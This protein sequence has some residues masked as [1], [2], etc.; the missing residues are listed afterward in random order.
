MQKRRNKHA[1]SR[2]AKKHQILKSKAKRQRGPVV[3]RVNEQILEPLVVL[4]VES[5]DSLPILVEDEVSAQWYL[6]V[7]Q[8][9]KSTFRL[10]VSS[11]DRH[12]NPGSYM[13][14]VIISEQIVARLGRLIGAPVPNCSIFAINDSMAEDLSKIA[15]NSSHIHYPVQFIEGP[16][17]GSQFIPNLTGPYRERDMI[18]LFHLTNYSDNMQRFSDLAVL[19][20]W[21]G[22]E[23]D[24]QFFAGPKSEVWSLDHGFSLGGLP[25]WTRRSLKNFEPRPTRLHPLLRQLCTAS[26]IALSVKKLRAV[27]EEELVAQVTFVSSTWKIPLKEH[28][29]LLEYIITRKSHITRRVSSL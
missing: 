29:A 16:S 17:H 23:H 13:R 4:R 27:S 20:A 18:T 28:Q 15:K 22:I 8:I 3:R 9:R 2:K 25:I 10:T 6:K 24:L 5:S 26:E 7:N 12:G 19:Y 14:A 1:L 21:L 11:Y